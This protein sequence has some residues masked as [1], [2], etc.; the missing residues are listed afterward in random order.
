[1]RKSREQSGQTSVSGGGFIWGASRHLV[2]H[3]TD[4]QN[5]VGKKDWHFFYLSSLGFIVSHI[6]RLGQNDLHYID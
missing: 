1:M 5:R 3:Q 6:Y 2:Y 4:L